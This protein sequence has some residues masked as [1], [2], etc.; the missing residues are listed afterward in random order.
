MAP[1]WSRE[2]WKYLNGT[3]YLGSRPHE[4]TI[5]VVVGG[6]AAETDADGRLMAG[7]PQ[8]ARLLAAAYPHAPLPL[9]GHIYA[10]LSSVGV[11]LEDLGGSGLPHGTT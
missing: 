5:A 10:W 6:S 11:T 3:I 2:P 8:A 7:A 1:P 4:E 9:R